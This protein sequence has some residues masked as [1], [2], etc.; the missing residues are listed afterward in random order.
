MDFDE[1]EDDYIEQMAA[2]IAVLSIELPRIVIQEG[3]KR[4]YVAL[5]R[6]PK[7]KAEY[8]NERKRDVKTMKAPPPVSPYKFALLCFN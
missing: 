5:T 2:Q 6:K 7:S 8:N 3:R 1:E 4:A